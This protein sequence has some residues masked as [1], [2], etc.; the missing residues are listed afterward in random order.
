MKSKYLFLT[1]VVIIIIIFNSCET[2]FG[3]R[4]D[5]AIFGYVVN[6]SGPIT[7]AVVRIQATDTHAVTNENGYFALLE[8]ALEDSIVI[9]AWSE[10]HYIGWIEATP[11]SQPISIK[12]SKYSIADNVN[13]DWSPDEDGLGSIGC[14]ECHPAYDEWLNDAHSQSAVNPRFLTMYSGTDADG[15]QSPLTRFAYSRDYG[16]FPLLP[17][18]AEPYYGPGYK[19][20]F[21]DTDG[22]C[23]ACHVPAQAAYPGKEYSANP[24]EAT[25]IEQEGIFCDFCHKIGGVLLN[26]DT[27]IPNPNMPGILSIELLRPA[28]GGEDLFLGNLDDVVG[29]DSYLPLYEESAYCAPCHFSTFWET[30]VYNSYGE[31][32]DSTYSDSEEGQ[33]CQNCHMPAVDYE[34]FV[35]PQKGGVQRDPETIFNHD[36]TGFMEEELM[37]NAVNLSAKASLNDGLVELVIEI[38]NDQTGHAVPTDFPLR[39]MILVIDAIDENGDTLQLVDGERIPFY[40]GEGR[41]EDGYFAGLPGKIYMKVLQEIWTEAYP[42]GAYWNPTRILSDSRLMPFEVDRSKYVFDAGDA[43][44]VEI[45][46][47]LLFRRATKEL[48]DLKGWDVP[49]ILMEETTITIENK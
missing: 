37:Q 43:K 35:Y 44:S 18:P 31:W 40:G 9:T 39:Q 41:S 21:P 45:C 42:S 15:N 2:L 11:S 6:E 7:G 1:Y 12:L 5:E 20:D 28:E 48:M 34:F 46:A 23:G 19:I 4:I 29:P 33:T 38:E 49:D 36:M 22:N 27:G 24:N 8:L 25:G 16:N 13:Y 10:G 3:R 17:D 14:A 47:Q 30:P 32:L 26:P